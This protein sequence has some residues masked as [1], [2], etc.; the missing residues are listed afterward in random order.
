M[1]GAIIGDICGSVYEFSPAKSYNFDLITSGSNFTDDSVLS[2]AVADAFLNNK[3][4]KNTLALYAREYPLRGYGGRFQN[5]IC[6][7]LKPYG[8]YGNG[9]AMRVSSVGFLAKSEKEA[10][11]YARWSA[12]PTHNHPEGVKGAQAVALAIYLAK[13]GASKEDIK[14][15]IV[16]TC[17]YDLSRSLGEI[18]ENYHF[19]VTCQGSVPEAIIAF[20]GSEDFESTIR[21]AIWLKGDADTQACIAGGIAQAFYKEIP[22]EL[23]HLAYDKLPNSLIEILDQFHLKYSKIEKTSYTREFCDY[24][25]NKESHYEN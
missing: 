18:E 9:S 25:D 12:M 10:L 22:K 2:L 1:L 11:E 5:W 24:K 17:I 20:L 4:I 19:D 3:D 7:D 23:L 6:S 13:S 15:K 16:S 14:N 21:N 8:S